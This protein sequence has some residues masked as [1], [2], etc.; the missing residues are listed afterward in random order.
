[1]DGSLGI[2]LWLVF[3]DLGVF[4]GVLVA[5]LAYSWKKNWLKWD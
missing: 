4:F 5:A 2:P 3:V 1:V